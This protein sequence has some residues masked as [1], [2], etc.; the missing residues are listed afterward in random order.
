[1]LAAEVILLLIPHV[2]LLPRGTVKTG[3]VLRLK[4]GRVQVHVPVC[5][6]KRP[7]RQQ[8]SR[9]LDAQPQLH[10]SDSAAVQPPRNTQSSAAVQLR[11]NVGAA[12]ELCQPAKITTSNMLCSENS[13]R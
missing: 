1:M 2:K 7:I 13:S 4:T 12:L 10:C 8:T 6:V 3:D 5:M 11:R 9:Y